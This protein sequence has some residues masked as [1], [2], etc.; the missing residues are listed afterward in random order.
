MGQ[1]SEA[2]LETVFPHQNIRFCGGEVP[3]CRVQTRTLQSLFEQRVQMP[4]NF[5]YRNF[6]AKYLSPQW[7]M[8]SM[9]G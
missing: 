6:P 4:A 5:S 7:T 3:G 8:E 1:S 9:T 2:G